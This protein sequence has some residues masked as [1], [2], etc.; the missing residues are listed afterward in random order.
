MRTLPIELLME[1]NLLSSTHP[2]LIL[3]D[4]AYDNGAG[5]IRIVR[6]TEDVVFQGNTYTAFPFDI[7]VDKQSAKGEIPSVQLR[8]NNATRAIQAYLEDYEGLVGETVTL[9]LVNMEYLTV[10]YA[11]LTFSFEILNCSTNVQWVSFTLGLPNPLSRRFPLYRYID[12]CRY[13]SNFKGVECKY[14]GADP[15]CKGT[16]AD[17]QSKSNSGNYG[18]FP[19]LSSGGLRLA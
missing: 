12:R 19:G 18:G 17:C 4:V 16:L 13:V 10:S 6:N 5:I 2:W 8:V 14:A 15:S 7:D 11:E 9:Y 1:K 3:L